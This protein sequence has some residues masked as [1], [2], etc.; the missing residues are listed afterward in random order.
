MPPWVIEEIEQ[1]RLQKEEEERASRANRIELPQNPGEE[2][3]THDAKPATPTSGV[4]IVDI[5]P[6]DENSFDL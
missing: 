1:E 5:S 4:H 6:R 2:R 3:P